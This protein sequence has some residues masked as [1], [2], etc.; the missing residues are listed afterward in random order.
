ML[1]FTSAFIHIQAIKS[2]SGM[3][4]QWSPELLYIQGSQEMREKWG[5]R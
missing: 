5:E 4:D 2:F 3:T 1:A